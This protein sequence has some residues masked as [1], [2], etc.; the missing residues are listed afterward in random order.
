MRSLWRKAGIQ[1]SHLRLIGVFPF[2]EPT[3]R[4]FATGLERIIVPELNLGQICHTV[5]EAVWT[6]WKADKPEYVERW[7]G[8]VERLRAEE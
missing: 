4:E 1:V 2:P 5:R 3:V 8:L 6:P 7:Q